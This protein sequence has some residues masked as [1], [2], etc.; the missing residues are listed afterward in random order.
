MD[1][2]PLNNFLDIDLK[3][4]ERFNALISRSDSDGC[5]IWTGTA[6]PDGYGQYTIAVNG[7]KTIYKSHRLCYELSIGPIPDGAH[8][9][10]VCMNRACVNPLH[11]E[12]MQ[13]SAHEKL[14]HVRQTHCLRGHEFTDDNV[15]VRSNGGRT[16]KI[17]SDVYQKVHEALRKARRVKR[18]KTRLY[19]IHGHFVGGDN[20]LVAAGRRECKI[21]T[22]G[23]KKRTRARNRDADNAKRREARIERKLKAQ[24]N[25]DLVTFGPHTRLYCKHGHLVAGDNLRAYQHGDR[26]PQ[27]ECKQ[28]EADYQRKKRARQKAQQPQ[29]VFDDYEMTKAKARIR[30]RIGKGVNPSTFTGIDADA[31][32][33]LAKAGSKYTV[34]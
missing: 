15:Y 30:W 11:L 5:W 18:K 16:C 2:N 21:C 22:T 14:H 19:C 8:L 4:V 33:S 24:A 23:T 26:G 7:K 3:W 32:A 28:C 27:R 29:R 31:Y 6:R 34:H 12:P 10:H 25:G 17:C 13:P 9:H 1:P 20:L